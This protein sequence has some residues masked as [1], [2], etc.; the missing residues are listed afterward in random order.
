MKKQY[1][2]YQ[3]VEAIK[4][5]TSILRMMDESKSLL[6]D[7]C[8]REFGED[9]VFDDSQMLFELTSDN[10]ALVFKLLDKHM[11]NNKLLL[12]NSLSLFIGSAQQ[13]N[14]KILDYSNNTPI[15]LDQYIALY[16]PDKYDYIDNNN[17]HISTIRK[18]AIFVNNE[19]HQYATFSLILQVLCHEMIH[20]Y[21]MHFGGL[22]KYMMWA[23][24]A[25]APIEIID[26][27][28]HFTKVFKQMKNK[29][30]NETNVQM[31][32]TGDNKDFDTRCREAAENIHLL[33]EDD[34]EGMLITQEMI[35]KYSDS[36]FV[37][38]G[39]DRKSISFSFG[40]PIPK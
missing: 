34:I 17:R 18:D 8:S 11:F 24:N 31:P 22:F 33:R 10:I 14:N 6:L 30:E 27:N 12:A 2:R 16:Q 21:D 38:F 13:L 9:V 36:G 26:Y 25:G 28:S 1:S 40:I 15:D 23:L 19:L 4:H 3:I 35:D 37:Q 29:F 7:A 39:N 32:I 5:W 20:A